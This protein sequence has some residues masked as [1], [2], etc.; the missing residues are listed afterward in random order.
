MWTRTQ[1]LRWP[2]GPSTEREG[3]SPAKKLPKEIVSEAADTSNISKTKMYTTIIVFPKKPT[4][5]SITIKGK[6]LE[7]VSSIKYLGILLDDSCT[8]K[9]Q[10][11]SQIEMARSGFLKMRNVLSK[12]DLG[13]NMRLWILRCYIHSALLYGRECWTL[14]ITMK[15]RIEVSEMCTYRKIM[16]ESD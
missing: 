14:D 13:L 15:K 8:S 11:R 12:N 3:G 5:C 16:K 2:P 10:I 7:L 1:F 9:M 6:E 4:K